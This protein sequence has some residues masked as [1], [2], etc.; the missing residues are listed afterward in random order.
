MQWAQSRIG[1]PQPAPSTGSITGAPWRLVS[2]TRAGGAAERVP[3]EPAY[4]IE[5]GADGRRRAAAVHGHDERRGVRGVRH[6]GV[7]PGD[8]PRLRPFFV[9]VP[10]YQGGIACW[11]TAL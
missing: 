6:R 11:H 10:D 3:P 5:F 2:L 1:G 8:I 7:R 9:M 4:T